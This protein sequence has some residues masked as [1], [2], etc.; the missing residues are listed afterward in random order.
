MQL[1]P[2]EPQASGEGIR[3]YQAIGAVLAHYNRTFARQ[4]SVRLR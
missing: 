3:Q 4:R 2:A 1:L